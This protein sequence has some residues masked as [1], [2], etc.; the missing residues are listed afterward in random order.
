MLLWTPPHFWAL[1]LLLAPHYEAAAVPMMPVVRGTPA[2]ARQVLVYT[3][4]SPPRRWCRSL[5]APSA[6]STCSRRSDWT[7]PS[8]R[9]PGGCGA[10]PARSRA[11]VLF[12]F[13]LLYLALL[14]VAVAL[15]AVVR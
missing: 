10:R 15:D 8:A 4:C 14:F 1:A 9:S 7:G 6:A 13:S 5:P 2:T 11:A 12:H 3:L